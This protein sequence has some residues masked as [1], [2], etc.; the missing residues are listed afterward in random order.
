MKILVLKPSSLGDVVQALPVARLLRR[1]FPHA[2][3]HWWL[4]RELAPLLEPDPDLQRIIPFD[5]KRWGTPVGW[6]AALASIREIRREHYDWVIDLQGLARSGL[7]A[8][9]AQGGLTAGLDDSREGAPAFY[10][11]AVS[12]PS[13]RTHAVDWYL[14]LLRQ[15]GVPVAGDFEWLPPNKAAATVLASVWPANGERW[16]ALQPGARW[17]NKR[18]P[19]ENFAALARQLLAY[20]PLVRVVVLGSE[21]DR[22]LGAQIGTAAG[23]GCLDLTGRLS[24][25]GVVEWLR[26][27][28]LMVTNDTGPMHIAAA[29]GRPVLALFGPTE[30]TRTGPYGQLA[31][32][33]RMDLPCAP[34]M[35]STCAHAEP[36]ACLKALTVDRVFQAAVAQLGAEV[37]AKLKLHSSKPETPGPGTSGGPG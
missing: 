2:E 12:R 18:W 14:E 22:P 36:L 29:L 7:V 31:H 35:K 33:L 17:L 4:N 6:P 8:W 13:Y 34:C 26:R 11:V 20:D 25:L 27:C 30:P 19:V 3:I 10:D 32:V 21:A 5:R 24:L 15:L 23:E 37:N 1:H 16:I 28:A 9:F